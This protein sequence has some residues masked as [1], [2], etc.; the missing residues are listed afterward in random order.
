M[1]DRIY[2]PNESLPRVAFGHVFNQSD[3][4]K[5]K[6]CG[7]FLPEQGCLNKYSPDTPMSLKTLPFVRKLFFLTAFLDLVLYFIVQLSHSK[8]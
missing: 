5:L 1:V 4:S 8:Y 2:K 6:Q 3:R 7:I